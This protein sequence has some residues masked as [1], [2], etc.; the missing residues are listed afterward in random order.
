MTRRLRHLG[1]ILSSTTM[2]SK[3]SQESREWRLVW[4]P[5][6]APT[7]PTSSLLPPS[8]PFPLPFPPP[9]PLPL[10][11]VASATFVL[12][13]KNCWSNE[14]YLKVEKMRGTER[15]EGF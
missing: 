6:T 10:H 9:T 13:R 11:F 15:K 12:K 8:T 2:V 4:S 1:L 7:T 3:V 14:K 5:P